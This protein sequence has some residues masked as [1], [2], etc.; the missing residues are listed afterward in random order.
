MSTIQYVILI[1]LCLVLSAF[2]SGSEIALLRVRPEELEQD[3]KK[4]NLPGAVAAKNLL[5]KTSKLLV[6]I[7]LGNNIVNILAAVCASSLAIHF[8]GEKWGIIISTTIMTILVLIFGEILPKSIAAIS[9]R[10]ISYL[11]ALPLY[12][13][14]HCLFFVHI[15]FDNII[16]PFLKKVFRLK[17]EDSDSADQ[18]LRLARQ[19]KAEGKIT[20]NPISI[21]ASAA[22][23]A[24]MTVSEIMVPRTE[25]V[26]FPISSKVSEILDKIV[27]EGH[28]R[29]PIYKDSLDNILG[30]LH[31]KDVIRQY[32]QEKE[33]IREIL[34]PILR[35][36][37]R[38]AILPLLGDMQHMFSHMAIVKDEFGVTMGLVTV[39]DIL[40]EIVGE[41]RDEFD[42][43]ELGEIQRVNSTCYEALGRILVIDFNR[44]TG[45]NIIAEKGDT[46]SGLVFNILGRAPKIGD[47]VRQE[48]YQL[49]VTGVSGPRI[50][51]VKV[52]KL[53]KEY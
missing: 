15:L 32:K 10:K 22:G 23:A 14:H 41:I 46:L 17:P 5:K 4:G 40:E 24:E 33:D 3:I 9:P 1:F 21:I 51:R 45:W 47:S 42:R 16:D 13:F 49:T 26:A 43:E 28:T 36:P 12:I 8:L 52:I 25:I 34:K 53:T 37:E 39:E 50:T 27:D 7:L 2:F 44:E 6:T 29:V 11:V 19:V 18:V 20:V 48:Q 35:V 30:F 38:K 31:I